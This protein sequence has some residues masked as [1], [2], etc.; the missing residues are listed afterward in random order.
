MDAHTLEC[1]D[2][3]R[4]RDLLAGCAL[5]GLGRA[6][7]A[8][9]HPISR[10]ALVRRWLAQV[11]ELERLAEQRGLPPLGGI[12]DVRDAL[13]RC[14]PPLRVTVEEVAQIGAT[15]EGTHHIATYLR[16]LPADFP[17]FQHLAERVGDFRPLAERIAAV[18]DE[19]GQV[20]DS[21]SPKLAGIRREIE[22]A[23]RDI[24]RTIERLLH[25]PNLRRLLQYPNHTFHGDRLVVPLRSEYR[26]RLPGIVHRASDSGATLY[27]EPAEIVELN[28]R[29]SNLRSAEQEEVGR[30]LW[31]LSHEIHLNSREI[32]RTLD[33]LAVID[34][35]VAKVRLAR[36]FEL[37]CPHI[38]PEGTLN[39]R[40]ARHPLL[41]EMARRRQAAAQPIAPVVPIDYRLGHDF[42]LLIVTGPNTGGKTVAL[43]TIGLIS[44]MVQ[45]GL[46]IPAARGSEVGVFSHLLIDVGDEQSLQQSL[47]TFSAHLTRIIDMLRLAG[48]ASLLLIDELGAGTDP[49]EGAALGRA[50]LEELLR[51]KCRGVVSTHLGALKSFALTHQGA[52][53]G[54]VQF[55]PETLRPTFHLALGEPGESNALAV[56][57]RLGLP[58]RLI[59]NARRNLSRKTRLMHAV[60]EGTRQVK[61]RAEDARREADAARDQAGR[62]ASAADAVRARLEQQ[63]ADFQRWVQRVVHLQPGDAVRVRDF[64]RDGKIVRLRL[65]QQRAEVD[66]GA[67]SVEVPLGD[68]LPP[69]SPAPPPRPP[70]PPPAVTSVSRPRPRRPDR[71][72][73]APSPRPAPMAEPRPRSTPAMPPLTDVQA[74]ELQ[75]NDTVYV[76]RFHREGRVVRVNASRGVA[77]VSVGLL[78]VEVPLDG[79]AKPRSEAPPPSRGDRRPREHPAATGPP[80]APA[81]AGAEP[82]GPASS[83]PPAAETSAP[84]AADAGPEAAPPPEATT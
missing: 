23:Q 43:K 45:A 8:S 79:L 7:A 50:I 77:I 38:G 24:Q 22:E 66:V 51:L 28:N 39:V 16:D 48:P 74:A 20:R 49:D 6:L 26:G 83:G 64:D 27:V 72:P 46:P 59:A 44:L 67:F 56:A 1:L 54:C 14:G 53:N 5:T 31:E 4:V 65:D 17:E 60:I 32:R 19:R 3:H 73:A 52:E 57:Q 58:K 84:P 21:A 9:I 41:L 35:V 78:E 69:E 34:L 55:D 25:D 70:R 80:S 30:L 76:K 15:L 42:T 18:I 61:R 62:A 2:F 33:A 63:Q 13:E 71:G 12:T 75:P 10:V 37:H 47:S 40:G 82:T 29:I 81:A 36:Q 68:I 11:E